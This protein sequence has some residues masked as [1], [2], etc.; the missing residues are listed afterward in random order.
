M[1]REWQSKLGVVGRNEVKGCTTCVLLSVTSRGFRA[2]RQTSFLKCVHD[3]YHSLRS[4]VLRFCSVH[5]SGGG[6]VFNYLLCCRPLLMFVT[7][8]S[9]NQK[10]V[11]FWRE[12]KI[13]SRSKCCMIEDWAVVL[14]T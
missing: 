5:R 9:A 10:S 13:C 2:C 4:K 11:F 1:D 12:S 3:E 7:S 8:S 14:A 6:G